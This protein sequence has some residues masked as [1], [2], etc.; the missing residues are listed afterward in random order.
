MKHNEYP[1]VLVLDKELDLIQSEVLALGLKLDRLKATQ[2]VILAKRA[3]QL[4][5][6]EAMEDVSK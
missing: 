6:N 4:V 1:N 3:K 2:K 5:F